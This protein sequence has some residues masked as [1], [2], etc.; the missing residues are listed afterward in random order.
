MA[1]D[2]I[3]Y[4]AHDVDDGLYAGI[5]QPEDLAKQELWCRATDIDG[6]AGFSPSLKRAEGV[7]RLIN[8][9]VTDLMDQIRHHVVA[10]G[11]DSVDAVRKYPDVVVAFSPPIERERL[12]LKQY[13]F[14]NFYRHTYVTE[15]ISQAERCIKTLFERYMA[16]ELTL[17]AEYQTVA[18][19]WG[20]KRAVADYI[21]GMTDRFA[22][23]LEGQT[24]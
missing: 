18:A 3:A 8:L 17:P 10:L 11:L 23:E 9:L 19:H 16:D 14:D 12:A 20:K 7:R 4:M 15:K 24:R 5:L 1:A 22:W 21:A 2:D 6:F 13:L